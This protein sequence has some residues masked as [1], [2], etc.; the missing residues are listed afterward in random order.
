MKVFVK[1]NKQT[2]EIKLPGSLPELQR[3]IEDLTAIPVG[4]QVRRHL[5]GMAR[6]SKEP[7]TLQRI[8]ATGGKLVLSS[9]DV[10]NLKVSPDPASREFERAGRQC[11]GSQAGTVLLLMGSTQTV[12]QPV[13]QSPVQALETALQSLNAWALSRNPA[14]SA[15][16]GVG[17]AIA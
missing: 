2:S 7:W 4:R 9:E 1:H 3:L 5:G 17:R 11:S 12:L 14:C 13:S 15:R 8:V 6:R 16:V 10:A